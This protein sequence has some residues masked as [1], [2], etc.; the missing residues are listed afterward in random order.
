MRL[1]PHL[2]LSSISLSVALLWVA[3]L[4][5]DEKAE[6]VTDE[7]SSEAKEEILLQIGEVLEKRAFAF[8][9]DFDDW[10]E[11]L[12]THRDLIDEAH[13]PET[14]ARA[15]QKSLSE[16]GISHLAIA[17]PQKAKAYRQAKQIGLIGVYSTETDRGYI[18]T[19]IAQSS[20][21]Y[22]AGIR[23]LD[24]VLEIDGYPP[25][26]AYKHRDPNAIER[27]IKWQRGDET[28]EKRIQ[29]SPYTPSDPP[30]LE[31]IDGHIA[32]LRVMSF[33]HKQYKLSRVSKLLRQ[34][35]GASGIIVDIRGN[36]GGFIHHYLHLASR[37]SKNSQAMHI[38][39]DRSSYEKAKRKAGHSKPSIDY[40]IEHGGKGKPWGFVSAFSG[41]FVVLTD[42]YCASAGD[43][44]PAAMQEIAGA[45]IIGRP[46]RGA[47]L[48][49]T[50]KRLPEGFSL[51][52]PIWEM[53]TPSGRRLEGEGLEPDILLTIEQTA[54]DD[55]ILN[56][57]R[58]TIEAKLL[59]SEVSHN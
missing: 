13:S 33:G 48:A 2:R 41:P 6:T 7:L 21:A 14:F 37:F 31:W 35:K 49:S 57:A 26:E 5:A 18:V 42:G 59:N 10:Q 55:Y 39:I 4:I 27:Q 47:L 43:I 56:V 53:V 38:R 52:F 51:Q 25:G 45:T 8:D 23:K 20:P 50:F 32:V 29:I 9:V 17:P 46:T 12:D 3:S 19:R 58:E 30:T 24:I 22:K 16:F 36:G 44:F 15:V 1:A 34:T 28:F 40:L 54:D 11:H